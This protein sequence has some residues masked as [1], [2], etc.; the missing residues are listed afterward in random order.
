MTALIVVGS[1]IG[2]LLLGVLVRPLIG[3]SRCGDGMV[4]F[5][6]D[7]DE[8]GDVA[9]AVAFGPLFAALFLVLAPFWAVGWLVLRVQRHRARSGR[10]G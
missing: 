10:P 5:G 7:D 1:V 3:R 4:G 6:E 9:M 8:A 2:Y